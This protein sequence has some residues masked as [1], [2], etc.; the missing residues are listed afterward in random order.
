MTLL[1]TSAIVQKRLPT[2]P[3]QVK[4]VK[5]FDQQL[6]EEM[7]KKV[8]DMVEVMFIELIAKGEVSKDFSSITLMLENKGQGQQQHFPKKM[9]DWTLT[10]Y[11]L[12]ISR[13]TG[14]VTIIMLDHLMHTCKNDLTN[15]DKLWSVGF[16]KPVYAV[17]HNLAVQ[18]ANTVDPNKFRKYMKP[19]SRS[20][21]FCLPAKAPTAQSGA[22]SGEA[23]GSASRPSC[24]KQQT[25]AASLASRPAPT[26]SKPQS[27]ALQSVS[28]ASRD[29]KRQ[30]AFAS[31]VSTTL[32]PP[33][34]PQKITLMVI[35]VVL[36]SIRDLTRLGM[37]PMKNIPDERCSKLY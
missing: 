6:A 32:P 18:A 29:V 22:A 15:D 17:T 13:L 20:K 28:V 27:A 10:Q 33:E 30:E 24:S 37:L 35:D 3:K 8:F 9:E 21:P 23:S 1:Q 14:H 5:A 34:K 11:M 25:T 31:Q 12:L 16:T 4:E 2:T 7:L 26:A 19:G 36:S